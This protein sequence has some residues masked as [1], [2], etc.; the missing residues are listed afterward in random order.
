MKT[1]DYLQLFLSLLSAVILPLMVFLYRQ[2]R[3]I[4]ENDL[5]H[6]EERLTRIEQKV[7]EHISF[8]MEHP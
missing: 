4:R 6:I 8:H 5:K 1:Y 7:N 3:A 2:A